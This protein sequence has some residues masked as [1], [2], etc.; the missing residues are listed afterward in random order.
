MPEETPSITTEG[1]EDTNIFRQA[2]RQLNP[3]EANAL[4]R[5]KVSAFG[6][7]ELFGEGDKITL[8]FVDGTREVKV[9]P[10]MMALAKTKL[11]ESVMW[12]VKAIT[13]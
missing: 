1:S 12:A 6:L 3:D 5:V 13:G 4:T 9:D 10:R 11:E 2:Y 8:M 7:Y